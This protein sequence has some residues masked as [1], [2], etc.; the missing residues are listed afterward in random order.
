MFSL[1]THKQYLGNTLR[2]TSKESKSSIDNKWF[3]NSLGGAILYFVQ[4]ADDEFKYS[5]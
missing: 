4:S 5:A 1:M 3:D 2:E